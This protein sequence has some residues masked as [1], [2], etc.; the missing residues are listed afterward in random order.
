MK[1]VNVIGISAVSGGGKTEV[2]R[3]LAAGL[4]DAIAL[5]FDDYEEPNVHRDDLQQ[6]FVRGADYDEYETPVFISHLKALKAGQSVRHPVVGT[7]LGPVR[8]V[9]ADAPLGRAHSAS[10]QHIDNTLI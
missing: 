9:I 4:G 6:W 5:H 10:G 3:V 2:T 1:Q 8:Y 7:T